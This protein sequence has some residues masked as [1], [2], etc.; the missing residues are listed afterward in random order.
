MSLLPGQILPPT[1]PF[2][3]VN[4]DGTVTIDKNWWLLIYNLCLQTLGN[5]NGLPAD[6]LI[7]I[8]STDVDASG[9]DAATLRAPIAEATILAT[10]NMLAD[11]PI[12]SARLLLALAADPFPFTSADLP[13]GFGGFA[14]PS[15][16][17]G[18]TAV[19]GTANTAMRS[20]ASPPIDVTLTYSWTGRHTFTP[21]SGVAVTVNASSGQSALNIV[22]ANGSPTVS[23]NDSGSNGVRMSFV[24]TSTN[25][26]TY[27][28]GSNFALGLG[29]FAVYDVARATAVFQIG[30]NGNVTIPAPTTGQTLNLTGTAAGTAAV[31][32]NTAATTGAQTASFA[33]TNKPGAA[34]GSPQKWMPIIADGT[35]YYIALFN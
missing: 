17:V 34:G 30:T 32:I 16:K 22:G 33:A 24:S 14:N 6:A 27:Q 1:E 15:A 9:T 19:N 4:P 18:P 5:G 8:E 25:G 7:D 29:E 31:T 23:L 12:D 20:D 13:G 28:I 26:K 2:G 3:K 11:P 21:T 35:T 10:D